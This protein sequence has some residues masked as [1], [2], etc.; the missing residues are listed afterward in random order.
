MKMF[1][2]SVLALA[3]TAGSLPLSH[4]AD[5]IEVLQLQVEALTKRVAELEQRLGVID[6][7]AV[8]K[9][10]KDL[11]GPEDPGN[12]ALASNWGFLKVGYDYVE[13]KELLGDPV[14]IKKGAMEF[15][16]YSDKGLK[17]PFVKFLF[18]KV[19][20]WKAPSE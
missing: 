14:K 12:S 13:V 10:I 19:N 15:W 5:D 2:G 20:D 3:M 18:S 11:N 16:Y 17:G 8:Q 9:V 7:P 6:T 4:A 1:F